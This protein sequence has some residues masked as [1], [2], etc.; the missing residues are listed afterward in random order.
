[1]PFPLQIP[2]VFIRADVEAFSP[3]QNGVYGLYKQNE[4]VY[5]GKGD[6]RQR[7]FAHLTGDNPCISRERPTNWVYEITSDMDIRERQLIAELQPACNQR[8]G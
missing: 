7:L 6:I 3:G 1:M 4:W 8:L 5:V 2:R